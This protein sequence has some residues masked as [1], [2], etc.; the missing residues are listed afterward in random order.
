MCASIAVNNN[1]KKTVDVGDSKNG[2]TWQI[3]VIVTVATDKM[4]IH[5]RGQQRRYCCLLCI[6]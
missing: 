6:S 2:V 5:R 3:D 4:K 1:K